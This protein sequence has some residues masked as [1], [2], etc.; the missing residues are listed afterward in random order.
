MRALAPAR[1]EPGLTSL[2]GPVADP[3]TARGKTATLIRIPVCDRRPIPQIMG[4]CRS[5]RLLL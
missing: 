1:A 5:L 4:T 3:I 2:V